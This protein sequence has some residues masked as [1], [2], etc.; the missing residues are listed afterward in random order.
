MA[1]YLALRGGEVVNIRKRDVDDGGRLLWIP[2]SKTES[3][4]RTLV[5]ADVIRPLLQ[6]RARQCGDSPDARLF[7]HGR[8]W[9]LYNVKR[10]CRA[11]GVP[12]RKLPPRDEGSDGR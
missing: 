11:V 4:R 8:G 3:G 9:V 6:E 12:A 2:D 10:L 5:V 1:V 7:A